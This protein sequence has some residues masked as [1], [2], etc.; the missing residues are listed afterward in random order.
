MKRILVTYQYSPIMFGDI[1]NTPKL[2]YGLTEL[3]LNYPFDNVK[4]MIDKLTDMIKNVLKQEGKEVFDF[5]IISIS[6]ITNLI[7]GNENDD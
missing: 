5:Q 1:F 7:K 4:D 2:Y 3:Q 6:D